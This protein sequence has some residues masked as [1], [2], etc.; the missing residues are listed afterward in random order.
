M[1]YKCDNSKES[2]KNDVV[3]TPDHIA[4]EIVNRYQPSGKILDPCKGDGAFSKHI[5]N[6]LWCEIK[7]GKDFFAWEEEIDWIIGN[8]PFSII[9]SWLDHSFSIAKNVVYLLPIAKIFGSRKR[10]LMIKNYGGIVEIYAPWTGRM[11]GFEFGWACGAIHFQKNYTG[12]TSI[13]V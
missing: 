3:Y 9:N 12:K 7:D 5:P 6:C 11:V 2:K 10:L 4:K 8:P 13:I 1:H